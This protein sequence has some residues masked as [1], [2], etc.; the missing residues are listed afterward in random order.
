MDEATDYFKRVLNRKAL[1]AS[2]GNQAETAKALG[3]QRSNLSR[4]MRQ[5]NLR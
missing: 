2:S 1:D 5:L 4:L 3:L